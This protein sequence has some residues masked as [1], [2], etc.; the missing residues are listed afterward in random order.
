MYNLRP[1][2]QHFLSFPFVVFFDLSRLPSD[3]ASF[4]LD[5]VDLVFLSLLSDV[6]FLLDFPDLSLLRSFFD[7]PDV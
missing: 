7:S 1:M 3:L 2:T 5:L 4:D 6:T